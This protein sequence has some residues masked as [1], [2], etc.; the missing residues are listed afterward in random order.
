M[1]NLTYMVPILRSRYVLGFS[2]TRVGFSARSGLRNDFDMRRAG[3]GETR[4]HSGSEF[5]ERQRFQA[6]EVDLAGP[7]MG[8]LGHLDKAVARG[9]PQIGQSGTIQ[10]G[11][12]LI[13]RL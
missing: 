12:H 11:Q 2:D 6:F 1:T 3:F 9:D 10:L 4:L 5:L 7:Q 8:N 13:D